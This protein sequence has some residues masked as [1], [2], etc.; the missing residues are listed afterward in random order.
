MVLVDSVTKRGAIF[1][2]IISMHYS[3][4]LNDNTDPIIYKFGEMVV[5]AVAVVPPSSHWFGVDYAVGSATSEMMY[6][7]HCSWLVLSPEKKTT[8]LSSQFN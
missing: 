3:I 5:P 2:S 8:H 6:R 7:R 1:I 4:N